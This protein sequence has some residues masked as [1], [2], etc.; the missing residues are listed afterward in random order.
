MK[1]KTTAQAERVVSSWPL[2]QQHHPSFPRAARQ[3]ASAPPSLHPPHA[4]PQ[5]ALLN[6]TEAQH[7]CP[8]PHPLQH[9]AY[10]QH[11]WAM[12]VKPGA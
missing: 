11:H 6:D 10:H 2:A 5:R 1:K 4:A 7:S 9:P 12:L 8:P 3:A